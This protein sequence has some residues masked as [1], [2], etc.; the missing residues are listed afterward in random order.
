M[1]IRFIIQSVLVLVC[2]CSL[3]ATGA[4][5]DGPEFHFYLAVFGVTVGA[6]SKVQDFRVVKVIE[7]LTG[8]AAPAQV[9]LP[10]MYIDVARKRTEAEHIPPTLKDGKPS[11]TFTTFF[12]VPAAQQ[13]S[14]PTVT[15]ISYEL[16]NG[17]MAN[18]ISFKLADQGC[19]A[20]IFGK[21]LGKT[22]F[23]FTYYAIPLAKNNKDERES[24]INA[25]IERCNANFGNAEVISKK[26]LPT[27]DQSIVE[28]VVKSPKSKVLSLH[29]RLICTSTAML[30][31]TVVTPDDLGEQ[32]RQAFD[33]IFDGF[34]FY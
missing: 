14:P 7:P 23:F 4:Q 1:S 26:V 21:N 34:R 8:T 10:Q 28:V 20:S 31:L 33:K 27:T 25:E 15:P 32:D 11:E 19:Q 12:Y 3:P 16:L 29:C 13:A 5:P 2:V 6:D 18:I 30:A 9:E 17:T 24:V 22:A